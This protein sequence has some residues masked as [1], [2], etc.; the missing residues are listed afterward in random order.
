MAWSE[1][2]HRLLRAIGLRLWSP[3]AADEPVSASSAPLAAPVVEPVPARPAA[4]APQ[5]ARA[6]PAPAPPS[7]VAG[8]G[9]P[10]LREAVAGCRACGLCETRA[11]TV[12][13]VGH[14]RAHWMVVGEAPGEQ[15]D[16]SG[17]PFVGAAG[18][19][20]DRMLAALQLTRSTE[21]EAGP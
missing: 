20:L 16:L 3:P 11:Q 14:E 2:Q 18:Q 15:E 1:H 5:A 8:L 13:G 6:E 19:L 7:A 9:W 10:A 12:F 21:G 17:E 4:P